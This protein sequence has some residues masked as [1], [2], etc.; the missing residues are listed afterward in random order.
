MNDA[1]QR[2]VML[3]LKFFNQTSVSQRTEQ[4]FLMLSRRMISL[5]QADKLRTL[6]NLE[7]LQA[8]YVGTGHADT[9]KFEWAS[10]IHRDSLA[11]YVG[12]PQKL[13]LSHMIRSSG[14]LD[15]PSTPIIR[16]E[17]S[18]VA[19]KNEQRNMHTLYMSDKP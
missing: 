15:V 7:A 16:H 5:I 8:R 9:T 10:N 3:I 12:H 17:H 1:K 14:Q 4:T 18:L 13:V 2:D 6:Q 11:S 19:W